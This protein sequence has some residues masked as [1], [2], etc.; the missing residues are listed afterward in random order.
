MKAEQKLAK[1]KKNYLNLLLNERGVFIDYLE[2]MKREK[3]NFEI[4][5]KRR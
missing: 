1:M 4:S 2:E 5:R 3:K